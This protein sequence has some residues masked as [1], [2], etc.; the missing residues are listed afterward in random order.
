VRP[1]GQLAN[2]LA[3]VGA[4]VETQQVTAIQTLPIITEV[5]G[6]GVL[7]LRLGDPYY[8]TVV[9]VGEAVIFNLGADAASAWGNLLLQQG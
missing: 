1:E 4:L 3:G 7:W 6:G 2:D 8:A 9:L 5:T